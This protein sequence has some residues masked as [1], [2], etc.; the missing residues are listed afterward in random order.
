MWRVALTQTSPA[1]C[2]CGSP[3][4]LPPS[5]PPNQP[6]REHRHV[7]KH[8]RSMRNS[9]VVE[10]HA[11]W[12]RHC[13]A[14]DNTA[15]HPIT[16]FRQPRT[17]AV[18]VCAVASQA[19]MPVLVSMPHS[20]VQ[21]GSSAPVCCNSVEWYVWVVRPRRQHVSGVR[22]GWHAADDRADQLHMLVQTAVAQRSAAR[23]STAQHSAGQ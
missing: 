5:A 10:A 1:M 8:R 3:A 4:L 2:W 15:Q 17:L 14:L 20:T 19:C 6:C 11:S 21:H 23:H 13:K 22:R 18:E 16:P 7:A 9:S 12:P